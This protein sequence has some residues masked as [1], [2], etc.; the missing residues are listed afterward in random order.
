MDEYLQTMKA[1]ISQGQTAL[2]DASCLVVGAMDRAR[3][4]N[5]QISS[6]KIIQLIIAEQRRAADELH[7]AY[8][9]TYHAMGGWGAMPAW[10]KR[11][12]G[13]ADMTHPTGVG[14]MRVGNWL[15]QALMQRYDQYLVHV[16][17]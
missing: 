9:D 13:Q 16:R 1:V 10:V 3:V 8:F 7:C 15:Y 4:E 2:P 12:L 11:G 6:M 5:G 17:R 14:A